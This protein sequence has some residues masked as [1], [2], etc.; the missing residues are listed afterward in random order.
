MFLVTKSKMLVHKTFLCTNITHNQNILGEPIKNVVNQKVFYNQ[1]K[2]VSKQKILGN[3]LKYI[4]NN[5]VWVTTS[6]ML[7]S[8]IH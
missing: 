4:G 8:K 1:I 2:N 5:N 7:V 3:Q 6:R